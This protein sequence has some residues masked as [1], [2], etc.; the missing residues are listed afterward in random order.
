VAV[1][2]LIRRRRAMMSVSP[3]DWRT[4]QQPQ[5]RCCAGPPAF[6]PAVE[7]ASLFV[8][9]VVVCLPVAPKDV[10]GHELSDVVVVGE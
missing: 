8:V 3:G 7:Q 4:S 10:V 6:P 2:A 1:A 5:R 9:A